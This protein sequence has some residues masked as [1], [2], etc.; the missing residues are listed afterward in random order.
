MRRRA[1][2]AG[3]T[4]A[5]ATR[6]AA[7][8]LLDSGPPMLDDEITGNDAPND[9]EPASVERLV[10]S[11]VPDLDTARR[12]AR[13]VVGERLAACVHILPAG[14]SVYRWEGAIEEATEHTLLVKTTAERLPELA[15]VLQREH[16]YSCPELLSF[17]A[18][19]GLR[20]YLE[21]VRS[22]CAS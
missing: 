22:S 19:G 2:G 8:P 10:V 14:V 1:G 15:A 11:T 13:L 6:A 21:W 3:V 9:H 4:H 18:E 16:P 5:S 12:L 7:A 20:A 17:G